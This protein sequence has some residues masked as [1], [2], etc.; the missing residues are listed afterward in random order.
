MNNF[1]IGDKVKANKF[2]EGLTGIVTRIDS[3]SIYIE[4]LTPGKTTSLYD[5]QASFYCGHFD[6]IKKRET[7]TYGYIKGLLN[8]V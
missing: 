3:E 4:E 5:C 7:P 1:R 2:W 6:L 8:E